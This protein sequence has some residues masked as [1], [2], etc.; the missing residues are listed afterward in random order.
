MTGA[1][2]LCSYKVKDV[3]EWT[4]VDVRDF[5]Q[6]VLPGHPCVQFFTYTSGYVLRSMEKE[7]LR[8]QAKDEE[9]ANVIW[10][11][12]VGCKQAAPT[13][14]LARQRA[15]PG[16]PRG[17]EVAAT[18]DFEARQQFAE[19][20]QGAPTLTVYV[21]F[22]NEVALQFEVLLSDTVISLKEQIAVR[23][24]TPVEN[25]RLMCRGMNMADSRTLK[26]YEVHRGIVIL[27]VP[28]LRDQGRLPTMFAPRGQLM[29]P[30]NK[31]WTP[32]HPVR[33]YLPVLASDV[34][35]NFPVT[36]EFA[37]AG[38]SEAFLAAAQ[39]GPPPILVVQPPAGSRG[40]PPTETPIF[41]DPSTEGVRLDETGNTLV[42][43]AR[44][45]AMV[46]F[47][48]RGGEINV[49]LVTGQAVS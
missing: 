18:G 24:G 47:G 28:H 37:S 32:A 34:A 42:A 45:S 29:V 12:L 26:S 27:M 6:A 40:L 30:G 7:D 35:R 1:V 13:A 9:A 15:E 19:G 10:A 31:A 33:P 39:Q 41:L 8:R 11:E 43:N 46:H 2:D 49:T 38:D 48:G 16:P 20:I 4:P 44:C 17:P 5:I 21:R 25:Q 14:K 3:T 22:K 23:E 36:M